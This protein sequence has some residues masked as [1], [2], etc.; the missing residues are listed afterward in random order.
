MSEPELC[1]AREGTVASHCWHR[2]GVMLTSDPPQQGETCCY[3]G[4]VR[5]TQQQYFPGGYHGQYLPGR[6]RLVI[7]SAANPKD[8]DA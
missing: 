6:E 7:R 4:M 5:Y 3:C 2:N 1:S 8:D